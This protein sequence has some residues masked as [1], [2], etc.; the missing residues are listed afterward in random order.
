MTGTRMTAVA[1]ATAAAARCRW[2][3]SSPS[4]EMAPPEPSTSSSCPSSPGSRAGRAGPDGRLRL[5]GV[6]GAVGHA[7]GD[8]HERANLLAVG[9]VPRA[10][11][12]DQVPLLE[13]DGHED[14]AEHAEGEDEVPH[15]HRRCGPERED[16]P[17][18][19]RVADPLVKPRSPELRSGEIPPPRREVDLAK[20][21]QL[22]VVQEKRREQRHEPPE[23][24]EGIDCEPGHRCPDVPHDG[25][26]RLPEC[27]K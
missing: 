15:G 6:L 13:L 8:R 24:R 23:R 10:V 2:S 12:A 1:P 16:E 14:V 27:E 9:D 5:E 20:P 4:S 3:S 18:I 22:E 17:E 19:K 25:W 7:A 11:L 21:E 26:N